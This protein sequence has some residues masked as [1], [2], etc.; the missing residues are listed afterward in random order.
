MLQVGSGYM[1]TP[2]DSGSVLM[3]LLPFG[4][5]IFQLLKVQEKSII[6]ARMHL[7]EC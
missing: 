5:E 2:T 6:R 1:P 7:Q 4:L 3:Q